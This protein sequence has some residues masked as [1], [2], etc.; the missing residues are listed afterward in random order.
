MHNGNLFWCIIN[1]LS[2]DNI[3]NSCREDEGKKREREME[4][5]KR[6]GEN[7]GERKK[8]HSVVTLTIP[9][10]TSLSSRNQ[11]KRSVVSF[12][13]SAPEPFLQ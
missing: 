11:E 9:L 7:E 13:I 6:E 4:R 12:G 10:C 5:V 2:S 3:S 8:L 1:V